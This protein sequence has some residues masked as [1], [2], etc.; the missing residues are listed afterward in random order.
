MLPVALGLPYS[1]VAFGLLNLPRLVMNK[2]KQRAKCILLFLGSV[3]M[4]WATW[5]LPEVPSPQ[6]K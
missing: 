1:I 2:S 4:L 3:L 5:D 6:V